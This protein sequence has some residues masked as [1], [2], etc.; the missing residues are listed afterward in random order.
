MHPDSAAFIK[1]RAYG[2]GAPVPHS[3]PAHGK[4]LFPSQREG[5]FGNSS[6]TGDQD[7]AGTLFVNA[8]FPTLVW[9]WFRKRSRRR[10]PACA[11]TSAH[12]HILD[13]LTRENLS[14]S[15][16]NLKRDKEQTAPV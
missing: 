2:R 4:T 9:A 15:G 5:T 1:P 12:E 16:A 8:E 3:S 6:T 7:Q 13:P 14:R 10:P 11:A